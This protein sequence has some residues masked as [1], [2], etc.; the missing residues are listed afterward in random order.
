MLNLDWAKESKESSPDETF[1]AREGTARIARALYRGDV[2][3]GWSFGRGDCQIT[4]GGQAVSVFGPGR[5]QILEGC[6]INSLIWIPWKDKLPQNAF[7]V[8]RTYDGEDVFLGRSCIR[9]RVLFGRF[10]ESYGTLLISVGG[11]EL[12][13]SIGFE[14]LAEKLS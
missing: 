3:P 6:S 8:G 7:R 13:R 11:T 10:Q 1:A 4:W 2:I 12:V 5:V 9:G 14:I